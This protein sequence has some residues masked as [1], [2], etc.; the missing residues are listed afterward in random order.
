MKKQ[1]SI[2][3]LASLF[4]GASSII[5]CKKEETPKKLAK[6]NITHASPDA[7][8]INF[9]V[10]KDT[11]NKGGTLS[12]GSHTGYLD[13]EAGSR[14]IAHKYAGVDTTFFD[15]SFTFNENANYSLYVIDSFKKAK[16][17]LVADEFPSAIMNKSHM[18]IIYLSPN[19]QEVSIVRTEGKN[20]TTLFPKIKFK[21]AGS[22]VAY[23]PGVYDIEVRSIGDDKTMLKLPTLV[24]NSEK[25]YTIIVVG[26]IG[27][28]GNMKFSSQ[29]F[30]NKF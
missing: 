2:F 23:N 1:F 24:M 27:E 8:A 3:A 30:V 6:I 12:Y 21:D 16:S 4:I 19:S 11:L 14:K 18:R 10:G 20:V 29:V 22:F 9:I 17:M 26:F 7:P 25:I 5:S 15:S 28:S 13:I